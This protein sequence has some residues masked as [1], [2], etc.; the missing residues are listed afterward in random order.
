MAVPHEI[1]ESI[2]WDAGR[3]NV[4]VSTAS[5]ALQAV[6]T[7]F[8]SLLGVRIAPYN[9]LGESAGELNI[10]AGSA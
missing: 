2:C 5:S 7:V 8:V 1:Y 10:V 3:V 9:S 4:G 6:G